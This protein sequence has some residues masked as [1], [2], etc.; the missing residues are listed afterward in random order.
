[1][2]YKK[3]I[4]RLLATMREKIRILTAVPVLLQPFYIQ[5]FL[6]QRKSKT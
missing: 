1:M 3:I 4:I 5:T 2:S 6:T